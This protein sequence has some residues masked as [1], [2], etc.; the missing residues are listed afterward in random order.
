MNAP[1][2]ANPSAT[3][4]PRLICFVNGIFGEGFGGG[5][6]Y[7]YFMART[8]LE[9]GYPIHFFGGHA[10]KNYLEK[11][12]LPVNLTLTD[13]SPGRLGD[14]GTLPGQFH[15]LRD[16]ARRLRGTLRGLNEVKAGD[17]AYTASDY[18]FDTIPLI[19]CRARAKILYL[20][21]TAPTLGQILFRRR[22]DIASVRLPSLYYWMS[23]QLSLR[24][25]RRC[26]SGI[27]TYSHPQ[28]REYA[29]RFGYRE[30]DLWYVPN[31]SNVVTADRVPEQPKKFDLA[32]TGRVHPQ[33]GIADLLVTLAWLKQQ[34]PDFRAVII[35]QS[36]DKLEPLL[37]K[38]S[39]HENVFF[40]GLVSEEEKF[41][42]L[43]SS[44]VFAMPSHYESW[45]IV[46][47]EALVAGVPV[48]AYKLACYPPVFGDFVRYVS[49]F[50]GGQFQRALEE[51]IRNQR[52]G[53]N[54][55]FASMNLADLKQRL[56]WETAQQK[57]REVL[58][59]VTDLKNQGS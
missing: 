37:R 9:A 32:W 24:R 22:E 54:N 8:A 49:P 14:V 16:F 43:K 56:S 48:V 18:W 52:A 40:S 41:R 33:K 51:E 34:L 4:R 26:P 20:G 35:G 30:S 27:V 36:R 5:D 44:R 23:Q 38:D 3:R 45:G 29:L 59:H 31:G 50:D 25:F 46:V 53:R 11:Q 7:F 12:N 15:L 47:A 28:I 39:L 19:R 21:M 55:Y 42:L 58:A 13:S 57:F 6:V 10:F 1:P 2:T 17:I